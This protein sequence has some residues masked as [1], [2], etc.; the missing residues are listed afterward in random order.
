VAE[1]FTRDI[2]VALRLL[3]FARDAELNGL[4]VMRSV[5]QSLAPSLLFD[6]FNARGRRSVT[7]DI[8]HLVQDQDKVT[9]KWLLQWTHDAISNQHSNYPSEKQRIHVLNEAQGISGF[10][11][12]LADSVRTVV[13]WFTQPSVQ[14]FTVHT[15]HSKYQLESFP[16]YCYSPVVFGAT[17][18]TPVSGSLVT[19]HY[20]FQGWKNN[21]LVKDSG[22]Y[23]VGPQSRSATL[24]NI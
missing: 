24:R 10:A 20:H 23:F 22:V 1:L 4:F 2:D 21:S 11:T 15:Q 13:R 17:L 3:S 5:K 14:P 7:Y 12:Q 6:V 9:R 19:G 16:Q 8:P 18:T